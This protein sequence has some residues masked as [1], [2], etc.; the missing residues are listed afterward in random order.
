MDTFFNLLKKSLI[1]LV[2]VVFGFMATYVPQP[3]NN[4]DTVEAGG[5]AGGAKEVTQQLNRVQLGIINAAT[6]ASKY[7]DG[8]TSAMT[9]NLWVKENILDGIGW[10][11]AKGMVSSMVQSLVNWINSGFQGSPAFV[12]D[13]Q[14]FLLQAG[15]KAIG[16]YISKLGA[17]GSFVCSPFRLDVQIA[18]SLQYNRERANQPAPTCSLS[19]I[20]GNFEQFISGDFSEGGWS[21][22]FKITSTPQTYT[23]YGAILSAQVGGRAAV[24]NAKGEKMTILDFGDGFL[25]GEICDVVHGPGGDREDCFI[26][27]PG[28]II[29][30]ALSFNLDSGRQ[31]LIAA[32][33]INEVIAALLGQL[34]NK[35]LTGAS[36]LLGL[37]AGTGHTYSGYSGGS[38][39]NQLNTQGSNLSN[40]ADSRKLLTDTLTV[41]LNYSSLVSTY[42]PLLQA[43][44]T[45][46]INRPDRKA[47]ADKAYKDSQVIATKAASNINAIN[48]MIVNFDAAVAAGDTS[49][50]ASII[51]EFNKLNAYQEQQVNA[52]ESE[53]RTILQ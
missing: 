6:T 2:F 41:Q 27:K 30:E 26:S 29:E 7:F 50:Q 19:G 36:G 45:N 3:F 16:E 9:S 1:A 17:L 44:S 34:A 51:S 4:I 15:D 37:S 24:I 13:L 40:P 10:A 12:Q 38:F 31:S 22:W 28:K 43:Y 39:V 48:T 25:S 5:A 14:G 52:S 46:P 21:N 35:A 42:G 53:W 32:D 20:V 8:I 23:P 11:L 33:E 18:V 47:E 49:K